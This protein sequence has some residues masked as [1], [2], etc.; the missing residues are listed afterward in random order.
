MNKLLTILLTV[1]ISLGTT[2]GRASDVPL[3][4]V[5]VQGSSG[6]SPIEFL[7]LYREFL[8]E[9]IEDADR[10]TILERVKAFYVARGND[11][12]DIGFEAVFSENGILTVIVNEPF[13]ESVLV[14]GQEHLNDNRIWDLAESLKTLRPLT[15]SGF[16]Q[17]VA[18]ISTTLDL[19]VTGELE[20]V[21]ESRHIYQARLQVA[22]K[23]WQG[24]VGID[25]RNLRRIDREMLQ[26]RVSF[27]GFA[28]PER[29]VTLQVASATDPDLFRYGALVGEQSFGRNYFQLLL[30]STR[31]EG[32]DNPFDIEQ[33][34]EGES[35]RIYYE[36]DLHQ[37]AQRS[38]QAFASISAYNVSTYENSIKARADRIRSWEAGLSYVF[39]SGFDSIHQVSTSLISG[40]DGWGAR[41]SD[42]S[43]DIDFLI[44]MV[45]YDL[46]Q[47]LGSF[48]ELRF[49]V[50][51]QHTNDNLPPSERFA[52]GGARIGGAYD[53]AT[54]TGDR[55]ASARVEW[56]RSLD[57]NVLGITPSVYSY[58]DYGRTWFEAD[59]EPDDSAASAGL[60]LRFNGRGY[61]LYLEAASAVRAPR[62]ADNDADDTRLFFAIERRF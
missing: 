61:L 17:A 52:I 13:I 10:D 57:R 55:G 4:G 59:N 31:A 35:G 12:R 56:M 48:G 33:E 25:N 51:V 14:S 20:T 62:Y 19:S 6:F 15:Q 41:N 37:S 7:P 11:A 44:W 23:A 47:P 39:A 26:A 18:Q 54:L 2:A 9:V 45:D 43:Q 21:A 5:L 27:S 42:N 28:D 22:P 46:F 40:V 3:G 60:G 53:P 38:V 58:Y 49:A 1:I 36:R 29:R 32:D 50:D 34:Y 24:A 8:G 30:S 16:E